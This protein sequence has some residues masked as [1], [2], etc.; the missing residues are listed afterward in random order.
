M[1]SRFRGPA[2]MRSPPGAHENPRDLKVEAGLFPVNRR[3]VL[4][5]SKRLPE[6]LSATHRPRCRSCREGTLGSRRNLHLGATRR[7]GRFSSVHHDRIRVSAEEV[8]NHEP[9]NAIGASPSISS[10]EFIRR[11]SPVISSVGTRSAGGGCHQTQDTVEPLIRKQQVLA[12]RPS[13]AACLAAAMLT[14]ARR[15]EVRACH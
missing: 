8:S 14:W 12:M 11:A 2:R 15:Q 3:S 4:D 1:V 13:R 5:T 10:R 9:E 7:G 6:S